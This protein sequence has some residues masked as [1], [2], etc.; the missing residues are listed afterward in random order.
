LGDTGHLIG[1]LAETIFVGGGA[2]TATRTWTE[3]VLAVML[4]RV[5]A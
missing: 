3:P 2:A 1:G 5:V 4:T